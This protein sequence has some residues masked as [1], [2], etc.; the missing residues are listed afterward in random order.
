MSGAPAM[1]A[2]RARRIAVGAV[3]LVASAALSAPIAAA[4]AQQPARTIG[5]TMGTHQHTDAKGRVTEQL[6]SLRPWEAAMRTRAQV[7][8]TFISWGNG[9]D[10]VAFARWHLGEIDWADA[11]RC[12]AISV[13]GSS[14]LARALPTWN[15]RIQPGQ[16]Q[17]PT[18]A[19]S[20]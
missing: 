13:T 3:V 4:S 15:R 19:T 12:G 8:A 5:I 9:V 7:R 11:L 10:P 2:G 6:A 20:P 16:H 1:S 17:L 18:H 14:T